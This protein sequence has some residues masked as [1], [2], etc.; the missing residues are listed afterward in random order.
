MRKTT[1]DARRATASGIWTAMMAAGVVLVLA[2]PPAASANHETPK[3]ENIIRT[4]HTNT[5]VLEGTAGKEKT[6]DVGVE[7]Y[8]GP[9]ANTYE[10]EYEIVP[11]TAQRETDF[12]AL[13][14]RGTLKFSGRRTTLPIKIKGDI[15]DELNETIR[16]DLSY[17]RCT[18]PG[19]CDLDSD[20]NP[21]EGYVTIADDDGKDTPGPGIS[22][23]NNVVD[24]RKDH[25]CELEV[26]LEYGHAENVSVNFQTEDLEATKGDDYEKTEGTMVFSPGQI[27]KSILVAVDPDRKASSRHDRF[28]VKLSGANNGYLTEDEG[29]C[30]FLDHGDRRGRFD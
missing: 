28:L 27:R 6:L 16:I 2:L 5:N 22:M 3:G 19:I 23:I 12:E 8:P 20:P 17:A 7:V 11:V 13:V 24:A 10:V 4:V 9:P 1:A 25:A 29:Q 21:R 18:G 26:R 14:G 15:F 30:T